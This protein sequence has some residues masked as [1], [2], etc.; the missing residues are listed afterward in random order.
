MAN[1]RL[2]GPLGSKEGHCARTTGPLGDNDAGHPDAHPLLVG[3]TPGP[4][5]WND[6][7]DPD[8]IAMQCLA[9]IM[10]YLR[11]PVKPIVSQFPPWWKPHVRK[12]FPLPAGVPTG[13]IDDPPWIKYACWE[14]EVDIHEFSGLGDNNPR[15]L[16]YIAT[17]PEL[18]KIK[19]RYSVKYVDKK[20]KKELTRKVDSGKMMSEVDET[21]WCACFVN[22]CLMKANMGA[23]GHSL[24]KDWRTYG[25]VLDP[26]DVRVGAVAVIQH[27]QSAA[28]K[29]KKEDP[30]FHVGFYIGGPADSPVLLGG[31]QADMVCRRQYK[32]HEV[33]YRWP[34]ALAPCKK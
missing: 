30:K 29:A 23:P 7:A 16:E 19:Y 27:E 15:I 17:V 26:K 14:E 9:P 10:S 3:D 24:A 20:T 21:S 25:A 13:H 6:W 33:W 8:D 1:S 12:K 2:T 5:G 31:N 32:A 28:A 11:P 34:V 4:L 22:W 18:A